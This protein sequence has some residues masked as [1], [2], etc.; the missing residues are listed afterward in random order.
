MIL[1]LG[2]NAGSLLAGLLLVTQ[3]V[4]ATPTPSSRRV[5]FKRDDLTSTPIQKRS[6]PVSFP[7]HRRVS[8]NLEKREVGSAT[9]NELMMKR[10]AAIA[11]ITRRYYPSRSN[12]EKRGV[13]TIP[14]SSFEEDNLYYAT[15]KIG[16]PV[17]ALDVQ[18]DTGSSDLWVPTSTCRN[19]NMSQVQPIFDNS[20][21]AFLYNRS[22]TY[23]VTTQAAS[24]TYGDGTSVDGFVASDV[25]SMGDFT[26]TQQ[27]FISA[28]SETGT[29]N[30]AG[31]M[32][33]AWTSLASSGGTPWWLNVLSQF[34]SPEISFYL[35]DWNAPATD[36]IA[37]GGQFT[38]GGRNSSMYDGE[39]QFVPV[40]AQDYW[41]VPLNSILVPSA[42]GGAGTTLTPTEVEQSAI[43]DSGSSIITGP[44]RLVDAFYA[45]VDGAVDGGTV[46]PSLAGQWLVPCGTTVNAKFLFG[47]VTVTLAAPALHQSLSQSVNSTTSSDPL[48]FGSLTSIP[49][50]TTYPA[51]I[52][53]DSLMKSTY[54]VF[55]AGTATTLASARSTAVV[56]GADGPAVGFAPLKGV[57]YSGQGDQVLGT[58]G[59]GVDGRVGNAGASEIVT[60]TGDGSANSLVTRTLSGGSSPTPTTTVRTNA[61]LR[62]VDG[63]TGQLGII[64]AVA[65]S[66]VLG[67]LV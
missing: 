3:V 1:P 48:C 49:G 55:R 67:S 38:L 2:N 5:R 42:S 57:Q 44:K 30:V 16:T 65:L 26:S 17:Q 54:C 19:C 31:L 64:L 47:N 41:A 12:K 62:T 20:Q 4:S 51:W 29:F 37:P 43:I 58:N 39:V 40:I 24:V 27:T 7:I 18:L 11:K 56:A 46:D 14:M 32:G 15:V 22:S 10:E 53:G 9:P 8:P 63:S 33:L 36:S 61:S 25:V 35:A 45:A 28:E 52:F 21:A 50:E 6:G 34:E 23:H 66:A 59:D 60:G 13:Q